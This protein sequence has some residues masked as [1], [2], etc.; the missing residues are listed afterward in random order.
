MKPIPN[1]PGYYATKDGRIWSGSKKY[2][3]HTGKFLKST[4]DGVGRFRVILCNGGVC[5][6]RMI[7]RLIL[8][9]FVEPRP[10]GM[11]CCHNDG[12]PG[13]N[14]LSNLRWDTRSNNHKDAFR[15]G[16][17][18][19]QGENSLTA[20]LNNIQVRVIKHLLQ[21]STLFQ[22]EIA[23]I[24]GVNYRT[25]SEIKLGTTWKHI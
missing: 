5:Y 25:I 2:G 6:T 24:F 11:E 16:T 3:H 9:T 8:E 4:K 21:S 15:H 13:N 22:R 20:K 7:H 18:N 1:F 10:A 17:I 14:K 12:D 19:Y 23:E